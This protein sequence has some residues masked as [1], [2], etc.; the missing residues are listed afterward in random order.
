MVSM[1]EEFTKMDRKLVSC[2]FPPT[3]PWWRETLERFYG[4]MRR[5]LVLRVGRRGGK[6]STLARVGV[7]EAVVG[8]HNIPPGDIGIV[9]AISVSRDEA[10]KRL[11][12]IEAI[13]RALDIGYRPLR[14]GQG[15]E[16][17]DRS[18]G[19]QVFTASIAGV[20]GPTVICA[21]GDEVAK[22]KD[23]ESGANPAREVLAS[24]RPTMATQP[25]AK[26]FL[27]SSP[28]GCLDAH[29]TAFDLG[30]TAGQMV[31]HAPTWVANPSVTEESTH[32]LEPDPRI[33][34]REFGAEPQAAALAAFDPEAVDRAFRPR[35]W[36]RVGR[37]VG[38][39][40]PSS[41]GKDAFT[42]GACAWCEDADGRPFLNVD[43]VDAT[44]GTFWEQVGGDVIA[45][46]ISSAFAPYDIEH[47]HSDQRER[48]MLESVLRARKL[49]LVVHDWT[50]TSKQLAV[51]TIRRWL[52]D[53][54]LCLPDRPKLRRELLLFEEKIT[55][56][57]ALTFGA[58]GSGHD[59]EVALLLTAAMAQAAGWIHS[60]RRP[61]LPHRPDTVRRE[62]WSI[63]GDISATPSDAIQWAEDGTFTI[64]RSKGRHF[65]G[66]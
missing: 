49:I 30:D 18:I 45:D 42:W 43:F 36:K 55:A 5:Q 20:S 29:A 50:S 39:L 58:R 52:R 28:L 44:E 63:A 16:L 61:A 17:V 62:R 46:K 27:S 41:G 24:L 4:S 12:T 32:E 66:Y 21:I 13:L 60:P 14:E 51:E 47:V 3:S 33:H 10:A 7:L 2:G 11:R 8:D 65:G 56:T 40:D 1:F 26:L 54:T 57:G 59:D 23:A 53:G 37:R 15:F 35:E 22:W 31:A 19:F 34:A 9:A 48:L 64:Q 38:L 6:S 25:R